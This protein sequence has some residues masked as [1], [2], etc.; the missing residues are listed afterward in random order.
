MFYRKFF[1]VLSLITIGSSVPAR[2]SSINEPQRCCGV[3][4]YHSKITVSTGMALPSGQSYA[5]YVIYFIY[6]FKMNFFI[7]SCRDI[8]IFHMTKI[9]A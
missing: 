7:F 6:D 3:K 4:E 2:R 8:L 9:V 1:I 5:S